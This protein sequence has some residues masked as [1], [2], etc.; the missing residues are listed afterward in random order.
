MFD[1]FSVYYIVP[2]KVYSIYL[3]CVVNLSLDY[4][5]RYTI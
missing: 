5:L 3:G 1:C 2:F 4:G